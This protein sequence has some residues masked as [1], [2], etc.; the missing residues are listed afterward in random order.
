[1]I[2]PACK[3]SRREALKYATCRSSV[4]C[5]GTRLSYAVCV[6]VVASRRR[7]DGLVRGEGAYRTDVAGALRST[8]MV[9]AKPVVLEISSPVIDKC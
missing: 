1:M 2:V 5:N 4:R 6:L 8:S 3:S 9:V 7:E